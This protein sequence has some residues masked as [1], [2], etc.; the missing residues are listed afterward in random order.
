MLTKKEEKTKRLYEKL[1]QRAQDTSCLQHEREAAEESTRQSDDAEGVSE[2]QSRSSSSARVCRRG[3]GGARRAF[4]RRG[5]T[6]ARGRCAAE[7]RVDGAAAA[8]GGSAGLACC[9][10]SAGRHGGGDGRRVGPDGALSTARMVLL[11][12]GSAGVVT[13][14]ALHT[15]VA[16]L[17]A[18]EEGHGLG[19]LGHI[20]REP[21]AAHAGVGQGIRVACVVVCGESVGGCLQADQLGV[22]LDGR[23]GCKRHL[24]S[25]A[26]RTLCDLV[27]TPDLSG[28]ERNA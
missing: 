18:D 13:V 26:Y 24:N 15:L 1:A 4:L 5:A 2:L 27:V 21:V 9:A 11:A 23:C 12:G 22:V 6:V 19:V 14:A 8:I 3:A 20:G 10:R 25:K 7:A 16:P 28:G 17:L